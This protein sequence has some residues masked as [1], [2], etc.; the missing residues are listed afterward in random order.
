MSEGGS[1]L[2]GLLG[3]W[4][5]MQLASTL[6]LLLGG[7]Y[8]LYCL[9]R[10]AAGMERLAAAVED[11]TAQQHPGRATPGATMPGGTMPT[12]TPATTASDARPFVPAA[13]PGS[14]PPIAPPIAPPPPPSPPVGTPGAGSSPLPAASSDTQK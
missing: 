9:S 5:M 3:F 12:A 10:A 7:L 11:L 13:P 4:M 1:P 14:A 6:A 2:A 8:A